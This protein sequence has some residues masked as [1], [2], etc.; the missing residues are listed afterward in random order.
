VVAVP[1]DQGLVAA[2]A[3]GL[4]HVPRLVVDVNGAAREQVQADDRQVVH[5]P[6][7]HAMAADAT[8][9]RK[10]LR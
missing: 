10:Q 9:P 2:V 8:K 7:P 6:S 3:L 5:S 4:P 1:T